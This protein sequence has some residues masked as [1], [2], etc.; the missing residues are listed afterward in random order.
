MNER[1]RHVRAKPLPELPAH[2]LSMVSPEITEPL[3]VVDI[4]V[5]GIAI[6]EGM[7]T[8]VVGATLSLRLVLPSATLPLDAVV[9]WVA[10]GMIGLELDAPSEVASAAIGRYVAELLE[11][12]SRA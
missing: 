9:R 2:V 11:R 5:S 10:R 4:S 8:S 6:V 7:K 1:R 3:D 12:G